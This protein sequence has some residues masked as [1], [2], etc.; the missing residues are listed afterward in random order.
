MSKNRDESS[1]RKKIFSFDRKSFYFIFFS[2]NF[3]SLLSFLFAKQFFTSVFT[4]T[5]ITSLFLLRLFEKKMQ[6]SVAKLVKAKIDQL[7]SSIEKEEIARLNHDILEIRKDFEFQMDK[8]V[9][10]VK[11]AYLCFEDVKKENERLLL[12][13]ENLKK[14]TEEKIENKES[15]LK[16]YQQTIYEQRTLLDKSKRYIAKLEGKVNDLTYEIRSLLQL[17]TKTLSSYTMP[18]SEFDSTYDKKKSSAY[19]LTLILR[20]YISSAENIAS[21]SYL[22]GNQKLLQNEHF[23]IDCRPLFDA[24]RDE[25]VGIVF[26]Y[27][28]T[29]KKVIFANN[30]VKTLLGF[31]PEK[32]VKEFPQLIKGGYDEWK[33]ALIQIP[34]V[35]EGRLRLLIQSKKE[36]ILM[37][38]LLGSISRGPFTNHLIGILY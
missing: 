35:K 15:L 27:S 23:E 1:S 2:F 25:M 28:L 33:K 14:E 24:F 37:N 8:K 3:L 30:Y 7:S 19:D 5:L 9:E 16:E 26:I 6:H 34:E 29:E 38:C 10:E 13:Y 21:A 12:E 22:I 31:N 11:E 4:L 18:F 20:K 32:F 36:E 17:E